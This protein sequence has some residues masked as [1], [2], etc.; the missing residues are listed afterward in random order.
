MENNILHTEYKSP[1]KN[2]YILRQ[3]SE[4]DL[5]WT[6]KKTKQY[7]TIKKLEKYKIFRTPQFK[8]LKNPFFLLLERIKKRI[9]YNFIR[10]EFNTDYIRK[11]YS[12]KDNID[13]DI[14]LEYLYVYDILPKEDIYQYHEGIIKYSEICKHS[15]GVA[16]EFSINR[17]F[18]DMANHN[19]RYCTHNL[20]YFLV[21]DTMLS[22]KWVEDIFIKFEQYSES[23]YLITYRL[24]LKEKVKEELKN[25]LTSLVLYE[26][27][28]FKA[29]SNRILS[30]NSNFIL[31]D[32]RKRALNELILD[33]EFTFINELNKHVPCF[34]H[35]HEI[36]APTFGVYKIDSLN[37]IESNPQ[38]MALFNFNIHDHD[39][40][41]DKNIITNFGF[42][43]NTD[44]YACM[45]NSSFF[46]EEE[47]ALSYL[48]SFFFP[49]AE[50]LVFHTL[51]PVIEKLIINNQQKL[52]KLV[53]DSCSVSKLLEAKI[54]TLQELN[55][56]KRLISANQKYDES[57]FINDYFE[58]FEGCFDEG[59]L[60]EKYSNALLFQ[61]KNLKAKY[62]DFDTQINSLYQFY[63]D[64][65]KAVE[66]STNIRLVRYTLILTAITLLATLF[67]ILVSL[68]IIPIHNSNEPVMPETSTE[69]TYLQRNDM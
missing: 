59:G 67:T 56:Y 26:P 47:Y 12:E 44:S 23:F 6:K 45:V 9:N 18:N 14:N 42:L 36:I 17:C 57:P 1:Y 64:N 8:K 62:T 7:H 19:Y 25:I 11:H 27:T 40:D 61:L 55:V 46:Q 43:H 30:A 3:I 63:D 21:K 32:N 20:P 48:D 29:K 16:D 41:K 24:K 22:Y 65:L 54:K 13:L 60:R 58:N 34:L 10:D 37:I 31:S 35:R 2:K 5:K 15:I 38:I 69:S 39:K 49:L 28:F 33:I 68:N 51:N 53:A 4:T 52:N 66:S 50:Y